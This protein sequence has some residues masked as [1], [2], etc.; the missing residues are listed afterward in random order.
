MDVAGEQQ[1]DVVSNVVKTRLSLDGLRKL[2]SELD[3]GGV[4]HALAAKTGAKCGPCFPQLHGV[5]QI[6]GGARQCCNSCADVK[7]TYAALKNSVPVGNGNMQTV[8][9][10]EHPV[11][12]HEAVLVDPSRLAAIHEG[13]NLFGFLEV[14]TA[15]SSR[16]HIS[17]AAPY[18]N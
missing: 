18:R 6:P 3:E 11:C 8:H 13:C 12:Q 16:R 2:G 17:F 5:P 9:W 4:A 15:C 7:T 1:I 14:R 10:E